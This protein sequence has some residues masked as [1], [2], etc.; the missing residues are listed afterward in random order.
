MCV[1]TTLPKEMLNCAVNFKLLQEVN[2]FLDNLQVIKK[3]SKEVT[4]LKTPKFYNQASVK[5][6]LSICFTF[7]FNIKPTTI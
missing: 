6:I 7:V 2:T 1:V 5:T 3:D 4:N